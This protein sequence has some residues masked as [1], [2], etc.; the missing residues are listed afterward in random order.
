MFLTSS[1]FSDARR[2]ILVSGTKKRTIE[3]TD[4][5]ANIAESFVDGTRREVR[6]GVRR[7]QIDSLLPPLRSVR[8]GTLNA[9]RL[10]VEIRLSTIWNH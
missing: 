1:T 6:C 3:L 7:A 4:P 8:T 10:R 5:R 2:K 9:L